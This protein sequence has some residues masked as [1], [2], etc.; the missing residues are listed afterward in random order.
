MKVHVSNVKPIVVAWI[1]EVLMPKSNAKQK[2]GICFYMLQNQNS[3]DEMLNPVKAFA[4]KDG[5]FDLDTT[6]ANANVALEKAGGV[7][8][9]DVLNYNFDKDDLEKLFEIAKRFGN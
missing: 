8:T 3:I 1:D 2:F 6:K 7:I 4:D 9:L 5:Y